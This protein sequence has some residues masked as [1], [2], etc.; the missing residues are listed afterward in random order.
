[1][2]KLVPAFAGQAVIGSDDWEQEQTFP[3]VPLEQ[4]IY[5]GGKPHTRTTME[6]VERGAIDD[7]VFE[8][9]A[10]YKVEKG[11]PKMR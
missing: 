2:T 6:S 7:S 9:P 1:M 3:G 8:T 10:G 11:V 4:T 5:I